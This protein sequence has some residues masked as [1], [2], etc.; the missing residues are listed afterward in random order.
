MQKA[1]KRCDVMRCSAKRW[2]CLTRPYLIEAGG[3]FA[4]TQDARHAAHRSIGSTWAA[5]PGTFSMRSS[6]CLPSA[7]RFLRREA[8]QYLYS[9][10]PLVMQVQGLLARPAKLA[11]AREPFGCSGRG[12]KTGAIAN[13]CA[14]I[15]YSFVVDALQALAR[16]C[17]TEACSGSLGFKL[18]STT[19]TG[20]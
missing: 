8:E 7:A 15:L 19:S 12:L 9:M 20:T 16:P 11:A 5:Q 4:T 18:P 2:P 13:Y 3:I 10:R 17:H 1:S 6:V 14:K